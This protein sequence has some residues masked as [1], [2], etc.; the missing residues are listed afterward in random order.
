MAIPGSQME[1]GETS[2]GRAK[3][4]GR[5]GDEKVHTRE[6]AILSCKVQRCLLTTVA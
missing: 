1:R 6:V 3:G 4:L 2:R 5:E